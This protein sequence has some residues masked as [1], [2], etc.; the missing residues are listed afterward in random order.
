MTQFA[1]DLRTWRKAR[2]FS[3]LDLA[4]EAEVS[5]RHISFLETGR[6]RPS[7]EMIARLGEALNLP[8]DAQN[9]MLVRAG[10]APR[11][12]KRQWDAAE[13]APIRAAL[14]FTLANHE[15]Y[16]ALAVDRLWTVLKLNRSAARLFSLVGLVEGASM[17]DLVSSG[18]LEP[19]L[20]NWPEVAHH[21][22]RRL[23]TESAAQGGIAELDAA[24]S[25]LA[26]APPMKSGPIGP[27]T[28]AIYK[29]GEA[30]LSLFS[31][32]AQ[33][34]APEDLTLDDM[35]IELFFPADDA[36]A[37]LLRRMAT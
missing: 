25:R 37:D 30:R 1:E 34:G 7:P 35:R 15:P 24:A 5:S 11:Y 18:A 31:T 14:D 22:A 26:E 9:Q 21:A 10:F 29:A 8:L 4:C 20:E 19:F 3:Q 12:A 32:I 36:T 28:P 33:F 13:M 16:P 17:L 6:A 27:V 23:R 2:R